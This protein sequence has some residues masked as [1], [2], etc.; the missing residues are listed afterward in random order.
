[1]R[2]T[3]IEPQR[4]GNRVNIYIDDKF[5][6]GID[7]EIR[8]KYKLN[9]DMEVDDDFIKEVLIAEE[10]N[11]AI[12][13]ALKL[14]S[15]RPRAEK[16]LSDALKRKGYDEIIIDETINYCKERDY[17]ND[18][19]FAESFVRDKINFSKLG[20]ERIRYELKL[21]GISDDIIN[22]VLKMNKDHQ[23]ETAFELGKKRLNLYKND[24]YDAKYRKLSGFLQRKG[25]SYDIISKVVKELLKQ[26]IWVKRWNNDPF[27]WKSS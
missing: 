22:K 24:S 23:F 27:F 7:D 12:N 10:K 2:I 6:I 5:A 26:W 1:M 9:L 21:K 13:Y 20:P 16:E 4:F 8:Y 14:L 3:K 25:F 15:Y 19:E 18:R 11:K 17:I